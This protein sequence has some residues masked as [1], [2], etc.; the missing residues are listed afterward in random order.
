MKQMTL[1]TKITLPDKDERFLYQYLQANGYGNYVN[2]AKNT[3][4]FEH[5]KEDQG[6]TV[7]VEVEIIDVIDASAGEVTS[8]QEL[9]R[10]PGPQR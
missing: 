5:K 3:G 2:V 8:K 9:Q 4:G 10:L 6:I 7:E 1:K